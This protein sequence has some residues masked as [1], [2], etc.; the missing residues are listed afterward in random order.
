[1]F[2]SEF[3][4]FMFFVQCLCGLQKVLSSLL[5][6]H[7]YL[8]SAPIRFLLKLPFTLSQGK[9]KSFGALSFSQGAVVPGFT[10]KSHVQVKCGKSALGG[11]KHREYT[12]HNSNAQ[13]F[14]AH[15]HKKCLHE[16]SGL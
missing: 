1:M 2:Y 6:R 5:L 13:L 7:Y 14:P 8:S 12:F 4:S 15:L 16:N 11:V 9:Q 3:Y 10:F